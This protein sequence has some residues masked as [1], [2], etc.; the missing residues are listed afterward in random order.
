MISSYSVI[1]DTDG[2]GELDVDWAEVTLR[3]EDNDWISPLPERDKS[4]N[5]YTR[6]YI[7][8]VEGNGYI[9][10]IGNYYIAT[11]SYDMFGIL[12]YQ[13]TLYLTDYAE[14]PSGTETNSVQ[15]TNLVYEKSP[16][17]INFSSL[18][19]ALAAI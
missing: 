10:S 17:Y 4:G 19:S 18:E 7:I 12:L 6:A 15:I 5:F 8:P 16:A 14:M 2:D 13:G 9:K 1:F 3:N 11:D